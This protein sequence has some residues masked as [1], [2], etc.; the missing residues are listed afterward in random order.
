MPRRTIEGEATSSSWGNKLVTQD[1]EKKRNF[2]GL[3]WVIFHGIN[4]K[5][6]IKDA[7]YGLYKKTFIYKILDEAK[8][9]R[10]VAKFNNL[11]HTSEIKCDMISTCIKT[12]F[13]KR[14]LAEI[15][16]NPIRRNLDYCKI[17]REDFNVDPLNGQEE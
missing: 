1:E 3:L 5:Q 4:W 15:M 16:I 8:F 12:D 13:G 2:E 14:R 7:I 17:A 9:H 11:D 10:D 6:D